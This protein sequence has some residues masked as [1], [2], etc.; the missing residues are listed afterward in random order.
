MKIFNSV[1]HVLLC[2]IISIHASQTKIGL[3]FKSP[4]QSSLTPW[5]QNVQPIA[6]GPKQQEALKGQFEEPYTGPKLNLSPETL[7]DLNQRPK[8]STQKATEPTQK[9]GLASLLQEPEKN[10]H[11]VQAPKT[12]VQ[13]ISLKDCKTIVN[14]ILQ[15]NSTPNFTTLSNL[16]NNASDSTHITLSGNPLIITVSDNG[17]TP[18]TINLTED[19]TN[20]FVST[21]TQPQDSTTQTPSTQPA[22]SGSVANTPRIITT[23]QPSKKTHQNQNTANTQNANKPQLVPFGTNNPYD[24]QSNNND[25][26][27]MDSSKDSSSRGQSPYGNPYGDQQPPA[28]ASASPRGGGFD[29]SYAGGQGYYPDN[30]YGSYNPYGGGGHMSGGYQDKSGGYVGTSL[31]QQ[32]GFAITKP[33]T[34]QPQYATI[35]QVRKLSTAGK[36]GPIVPQ[37]ASETE[38]TSGSY[39]RTVSLEPELLFHTRLTEPTKRLIIAPVKEIIEEPVLAQQEQPKKKQVSFLE[40]L[41]NTVTYPFVT[42]MNWCLSFFDR[43]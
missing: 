43:K 32:S 1:I 5:M 11:I 29:D 3:G 38:E 23:P 19:E 24:S 8:D 21:P 39:Q 14:S 34:A 10:P 37:S 36:T 40:S 12:F 20:L 16:L 26:D 7:E 25:T 35:D 15:T 30:S 18:T 31:T 17:G 41:W 33:S 6:Q 4:Y 27:T 42:V 22:T 9:V 2:G 13:T 28:Q